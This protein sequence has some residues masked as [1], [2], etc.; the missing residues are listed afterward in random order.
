TRFSRD[1][2]SDVCSSDLQP[3]ADPAYRAGIG[4]GLL[5][6]DRESAAER[7]AHHHELA[8][9]LAGAGIQRTHHAFRRK[10]AAHGPQLTRAHADLVYP[11]TPVE[12]LSAAEE[13]GSH[14]E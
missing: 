4:Q 5:H 7:L 3:I 8:L 12:R 9:D 11:E 6:A 14:R 2:S 1:W 10:N 13:G